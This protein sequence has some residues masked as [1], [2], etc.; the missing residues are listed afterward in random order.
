[1]TEP[2]RPSS[3]PAEPDPDPAHTPTPT[4]PPRKLSRRER[5][6]QR[7]EAQRRR[8]E[9]AR[10]TSVTVGFAFDAL[11]YDTDTGA[12]VLA[13]AL[14]F[15]VFLFQVPYVCFF[16]II[17]G[18]V[19]D[20]TGRSI[21]SMFRGRGIA[22]LTARS[23]QGAASL[24]GW[25]RFTG[26]L[27]VAYALFLTARA[28]VKV[29]SIVHSLVWD[30]PRT[31]LLSANRAGFAFVGI[32]TVALVLSY[33]IGELRA[34]SSIGGITALIL[35]TIVPFLGWWYVSWWLPHR[36]CPL[37]VLAPGAALFA[38]GTEILHIVTVIWFPHY[39]DSK[40]E[41][42]GTIGLSVALLLWAYFV[43]RLITLAAV[44]NA[45]LW[46]RFGADST[47]PIQL[48]RPS[49]KVPLIDHKLGRLWALMFG[50]TN[51][52]NPDPPANAPP[53]PEP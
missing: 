42:Y 31:R 8:L 9:A 25:A 35:F 23:V 24:S 16:V 6:N 11:G 30:V 26:F 28:F 22:S 45:A 44:L 20:M 52:D 10:G 19:A 32:V 41:I 1:M 2:T 7:I 39:L 51:H 43:G 53:P 40:S 38:I 33:L 3:D 47:H 15:R 46:T 34:R 37:I 13:A 17:A 18:F 5:V 21:D 4:E 29:L 14:G 50:D 36:D 27:F 49:W 12:P 48:R